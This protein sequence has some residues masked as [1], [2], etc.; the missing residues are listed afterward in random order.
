VEVIEN[1]EELLPLLPDVALTDAP[2][3]PIVIV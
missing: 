3:P 1:A 2:P